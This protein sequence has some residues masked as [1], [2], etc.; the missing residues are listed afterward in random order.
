MSIQS[1]YFVV[2]VP[3]T[4]EPK[5]FHSYEDALQHATGRISSNCPKLLIFRMTPLKEVAL[6]STVVVGDLDG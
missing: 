3:F 6:H 1:E 2:C 5:I 4:A